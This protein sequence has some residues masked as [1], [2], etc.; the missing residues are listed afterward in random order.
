M[1]TVA[2]LKNKHLYR[3]WFISLTRSMI[4]SPEKTA[5][6]KK[7]INDQQGKY[8]RHL[9]KIGNLKP[10]RGIDLKNRFLEAH[11]SGINLAIDQISTFS[12]K[13]PELAK[14]DLIDPRWVRF[15]VDWS[16]IL[17][18]QAAA[19][20]NS[21]SDEGGPFDDADRCVD[22]WLAYDTALV[23]LGMAQDR[24]DDCLFQNSNPPEQIPV[25]DDNPFGG[26]IEVDPCV[27]QSMAVV[28]AENNVNAAW[29]DIRVWC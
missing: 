9:F 14:F 25:D 17:A 22:A 20:C 13:Y 15:V 24:L 28:L 29:D 11:I 6:V 4:A 27:D 12:Q 21:E 8:F 1:E 18:G 2:L 10:R 3:I 5:E 7:L 23:E 19:A 16:S 26:G